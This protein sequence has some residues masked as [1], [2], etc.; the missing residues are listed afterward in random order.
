MHTLSRTVLVTLILLA[1][2]AVA[3]AQDDYA[4]PFQPATGD[5]QI[6]AQLADFNAHAASDV[7]GF[8]SE[9][10]TR[11]RARPEL[12]REYVVERRWPPGDVYYACGLAVYTWHSCATLL[13]TYERVNHHGW[14]VLARRLGAAS[15][16]KVFLMIKADVDAVHRKWY[17]ATDGEEAP[18]PAHRY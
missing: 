16:S 14:G 11:Y 4:F 13:S 15:G 17:G 8:V 6:D 10:V 3:V 7:D 1:G 2:S 5:H 18:E 9:A 12:V